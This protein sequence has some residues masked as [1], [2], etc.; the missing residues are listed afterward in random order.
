MFKCSVL[1][2]KWF[3]FRI[4]LKNSHY[5]LLR[6]FLWSNYWYLWSIVFFLFVYGF[7]PVDVF[8]WFSRQKGNKNWFLTKMVHM[9]F[10]HYQKRFIW[11]ITHVCIL[12]GDISIVGL[13]SIRL[14]SLLKNKTYLWFTYIKRMITL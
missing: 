5:R 10:N 13:G 11:A 14:M 1:I 4:V 8:F 7:S 3:F 9:I 12:K 6:I 2:V